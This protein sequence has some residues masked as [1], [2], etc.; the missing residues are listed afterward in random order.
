MDGVPSDE[1]CTSGGDNSN[2]GSC[3]GPEEDQARLRLKRKLQRNR[4]SFTNEQI[5][6]LEKEFERTHYPDVFARERLAAK[7]GLPEAR[8]QVWFSN[9]RAKWRR[10][11]KLRNQRRGSDQTAATSEPPPS[12]TRISNFT[13]NSMYPAIPTPITMHDSYSSMTGFSM[14]SAG[15]MSPGQTACLQQRSEYCMA[16]NYDALSLPSYPAPRHSPCSPSQNPYQSQYSTNTT[17]STG[18]ISPG[19]SVPIAVPGQGP[20]MSAQYWPRLQ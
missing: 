15:A 4:T 18:L 11:E 5:D 9:R 14:V 2:P 3:V 1:T 8:I 7:I 16:R 17:S 19:V 20:D 10:E 13:S 12:P 6:S